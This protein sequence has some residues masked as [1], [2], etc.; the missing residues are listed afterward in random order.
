[1]LKIIKLF[2]KLLTKDKNED[3]L[4][5]VERIKWQPIARKVKIADLEENLNSERM[6]TTNEQ[7]IQKYKR[8]LEILVPKGGSDGTKKN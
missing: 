1:M 6:E 4:E 5:Y 3:Y 2:L 8:A 7:L